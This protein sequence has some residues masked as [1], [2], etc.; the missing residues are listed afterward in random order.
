MRELYRKPLIRLFVV[1]GTF[2]ALL[3]VL[4]VALAYVFDLRG[5]GTLLANSDVALLAIAILTFS[6]SATFA[7]AAI[8]T[9]VMLLP[10][11]EEDDAA[12]GGVDADGNPHRPRW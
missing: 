11:R 3:G 7:G 10:E 2:G 4:F 6:V 12:Y 1:N 8:G 5:L 9:A